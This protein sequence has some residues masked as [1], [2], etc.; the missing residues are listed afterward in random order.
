MEKILFLSINV[1]FGLIRRR[2]G[3]KNRE[4]LKIT[5]TM[6]GVINVNLWTEIYIFFVKSIC[7]SIFV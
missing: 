5:N 4:M 2:F 7:L 3:V 1:I 6:S